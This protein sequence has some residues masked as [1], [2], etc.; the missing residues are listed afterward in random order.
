MIK[1]VSDGIE[2]VSQ[3]SE[4]SD[5]LRG[6]TPALGRR[7]VAVGADEADLRGGPD[8]PPVT[9]QALR[10]RKKDTLDEQAGEEEANKKGKKAVA[11]DAEE[12]IGVGKVVGKEVEACS[13]GLD[14]GKR[15]KTRSPQ[16][17]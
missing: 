13:L 12:V 1:N 2:L 6:N 16:R 17:G 11:E 14:E 3:P 4:P 8:A 10:R 15:T 5:A 9:T 7:A